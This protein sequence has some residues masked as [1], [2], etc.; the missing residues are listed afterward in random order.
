MSWFSNFFKNLFGGKH[1]ENYQVPPQPVPEPRPIPK[2]EPW[3]SPAT[4]AASTGSDVTPP[5]PYPATHNFGDWRDVMEGESPDAYYKRTGLGGY[6]QTTEQL[7][8]ADEARSKDTEWGK[9]NA[10][11]RLSGPIDVLSLTDGEK[12]FLQYAEE[13]YSMPYSGVFYAVCNGLKRDIDAAR[14][15]ANGQRGQMSVDQIAA[16]GKPRLA[17]LVDQF[18]NGLL[19][20]KYQ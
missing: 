6:G 19:K 2:A 16:A 4:P 20:P 9:A 10:N 18:K 17:G 14:A 15:W 1:T 12:L 8:A 5:S 13:N 11:E 3:T 7:R